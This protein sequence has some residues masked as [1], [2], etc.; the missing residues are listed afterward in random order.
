[1]SSFSQL[2]KHDIP[3]LLKNSTYEN[4]TLKITFSYDKYVPSLNSRIEN[5]LCTTLNVEMGLTNKLTSE[6]VSTKLDLLYIPVET[7]I[8]FSVGNGFKQILDLYDK[9]KGWYLLKG[10]PKNNK[11]WTIEDAIMKFYPVSGKHL[12]FACDNG[13]I[14]VVDKKNKKVGL[15]DFLKAFSGKSYKELFD[16]LGTNKYIINS[17]RDEKP[18]L[19]SVIKTG[20]LFVPTELLN[21][22]NDTVITKRVRRSL[23][24]PQYLAVNEVSRIRLESNTSFVERAE[25]TELVKKIVLP[26]GT[27]L[28]PG[29]KLLR[30]TL[31]IIDKCGIDSI[32][33]K[34][35]V[36]SSDSSKTVKSKVFELKKYGYSNDRMT[37]EELLTMVNMYANL[38]DGFGNFDEEYALTARVLINYNQKVIEAIKEK[39]I[40]IVSD[41][42][43][44][45]DLGDNKYSV[46]LW[47]LL[48]TITNF[49]K[50]DLIEFLK[51]TDAKEMQMADTSNPI[52]YASKNSKITINFKGKGSKEMVSVQGSQR[53]HLDS[54]ESP[55][56]DKVGL[57]QYKTVVSVVDKN[58][59]STKPYIRIKNGV[60]VSDEPEYLTAEDTKYA[61][62][63]EWNEKFENDEIE[64]FYDGEVVKVPKNRVTL[65]DYSPYDDMG[66]A[67]AS[68]PFQEFSNAKRLLMGSNYHRQADNIINPE[69]AIIST[70]S[71]LFLKG[72]IYTAKDLLNEYWDENSA[73]LKA[74]ITK[75]EFV[76]SPI[77]L[78]YTR[79]SKDYRT[80]TFIVSTRFNKFSFVKKLPFLQRNS[81]GS[82]FTYKLNVVKNNV[83]SGDDVVLYNGS[84]DINNY[85]IEAF[86][87]F[88]HMRVDPL[89]DLKHGLALGRNLRV[90]FKTF[91][92]SNIED[93]IVIR[94]GLVYENK[95]TSVLQKE[96]VEECCNTETQSEIFGFPDLE[97]PPE[98]YIQAN[99]LPKV[100]TFLK[101]GS[102]VICKYRIVK[103]KEI[104]GVV[105]TTKSIR[106]HYLPNNIAG[107]VKSATIEGDRAT[108]VISTISPI[109]VGDKMAGRY[110]NK[111][112]VGRIVP[113]EDMPYDSETGIPLD[114]CLNPN[115]VPS[116]M[117]LSQVLEVGLAE[118]MNI[119]GKICI[120]TPFKENTIE[121][122]KEQM[123]KS[124]VHNK[125]MIDGRTGRPFYRPIY[126]GFMYMFKLEH[127][128]NKKINS[129]SFTNAINPI[130]NQPLKGASKE[131]GQAFSEYEM[132][133]M[134][135]SNAKA[136]LNSLFSLQSDDIVAQRN[137]KEIIYSN[138]NEVDVKAM[139]NN[140]EIMQVVLRSFNVEAEVVGD[141]Y[142]FP[143]LTD[144]KTK[145]LAQSPLDTN[146]VD[147]LYY[148]FDRN[149]RRGKQKILPRDKWDWIYLG[150]ELVHPNW[151]IKSK[152]NEFIAVKYFTVK[153]INE[154][155]IDYK[156][157]LST[158]KASEFANILDEKS[159]VI[160][161]EDIPV[162]ISA[163]YAKMI[164]RF[165]YETGMSAIVRLFKTANLQLALDYYNN[166]IESQ[167]EKE[168][169]ENTKRDYFSLLKTKN[170]IEYWIENNRSLKD[171]VITTFPIIPQV[172]RP[173][174]DDVNRKHVFNQHYERIFTAIKEVKISKTNETV[175]KLYNRI[176]E[177]IGLKDF[178]K[179]GKAEIQTL[180]EIYMG[181]GKGRGKKGLLRE[182]VIK[183]RLHMSGRSVI[184][185][186]QNENLK[187]NEVGVPLLMA[188]NIWNLQLVS[189]LLKKFSAIEYTS[190]IDVNIDEQLIKDMINAIAID[191][192][193]KFCKLLNTNENNEFA[194]DLYY[195]TKK[196]IIK[197]LE[198]QVVL[199]GRQPSLQKSSC[200]AFRVRITFNK[201]IELNP[202]VCKG[203]NAD[204]DG[205]QMY[206][207]GL[208]QTQDAK[209]A[210]DKMSADKMVINPKDSS[211]LLEHSQD[212][213]LGVYFATMLHDNVKSVYEHP[214][215]NTIHCV[216]SL[217]ALDLALEL[218]EIHPHD[219]VTVEVNGRRY[220]ST[221][222]RIQF[223][224]LL[225]NGFT[226]E[227]F[228]NN[229][230]L[231]VI[232]AEN[233]ALCGDFNGSQVPAINPNRYC[234]L[235]FDGL[236]SKKGGNK[237]GMVYYSLSKYTKELYYKEP[238]DV[239]I[240]VYQ[241]IMK[242]G[243]RYCDLSGITISLDDLDIN[244]D[245]DSY[246][247]KAKAQADIVNQAFY[248]G[249]VS[250]KGRKS[251]VTDI[252]NTL[253]EYLKNEVIFKQ[254]P[255]NN[256]LAIML[257]SGSRGDK[258]Q[259]MQTLGIV[260]ISMKTGEESL[261]TPILNSYSTGLTSFELFLA[262]YGARVGVNSTQNETADAGYA[263]RQ[264]VY[265]CGGT[266][267]VEDDCGNP[268]DIV[269][270]NYDS[271]AYIVDPKGNITH[272]PEESKKIGGVS[273]S[274]EKAL[275]VL[276]GK[277]IS[278]SDELCSKLLF[279]FLPADR[280]I[281]SECIRQIIKHKVR[282]VTCVSEK[283]INGETR[284]V[285]EVYQLRY[286]LNPTIKDLLLYRYLTEDTLDLKAGTYLTESD[287]DKIEKA[288]L[289]KLHVR[290]LF[291]C[292]SEG[293]V[294]AKCFGL[295][296]DTLQL[297]EINEYV[298]IESAQSI[299][300]PAAQL[301]MSLFHAGGISGGASSGV[302]FFKQCIKG[303]EP[304]KHDKAC[305]SKVDGYISYKTLGK[306]AYINNGDLVEVVD[307]DKL[308]V[309]Q[310]EY[311]Q[312]GTQLTSGVVP[313][314][315]IGDLRPSLE[316]IRKRQ[317]ELLEVYDNV[318]RSNNLT[319]HA[320]HFE[321]LVR[322]QT[323]L[324][325]IYESDDPAIPVGSLKELATVLTSIEKGHHIVYDQK[326]SK[327]NEVISHFS[328]PVSSLVFERFDENLASFNTRLP[329]YYDNSIMGR[330]A[331]GEDVRD[332]FD[333]DGNLLPPKRAKLVHGIFKAND[334]EDFEPAEELDSTI[335]VIDFN[336]STVAMNLEID[337]EGEN[338]DFAEQP[339]DDI[340]EHID[341]DE[342]I[343][344]EA[345]KVT[346]DDKLS[347]LEVF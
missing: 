141:K 212:M 259:L 25:G 291:T 82:T 239:C 134:I 125:I 10:K 41:L 115:G 60:A 175:L 101:A 88:G 3:E 149:R 26:D 27:I 126:V 295:K 346:E 186:T 50:N 284:E 170:D 198:N 20:E 89:K 263:T 282:S 183:K 85:D 94:R 19:D 47:D 106:N 44:N 203:Y 177:F 225:P 309:Q 178:G 31:E 154:D 54:I 304:K 257:D 322:V 244:I 342:I 290:L 214:A 311:V 266:R 173:L 296:F 314:N 34:K 72:L 128:V 188:V 199:F 246:I 269:Y 142:E 241:E 146:N 234:N 77:T 286:K 48:T 227:P 123:K 190:K 66:I 278:T 133:C 195:N 245:L 74:T 315:E 165:N 330:I 312:V 86:A 171:Y 42:T 78:Q 59:L 193:A 237:D 228:T 104:D 118:A 232:S 261:E 220:L 285:E 205:D 13:K 191:N 201:A 337:T 7:E 230:K 283:I 131:G 137:L 136:P 210:F 320:R 114:V 335:E 196:F 327:Q 16:L 268:D 302:Q 110:G 79:I 5:T 24:N 331:I 194:K 144:A 206:L 334:V 28:Q 73:T 158:L 316:I 253:T 344:E 305:M 207:I 187:I 298:G 213:V 328:G 256:N 262:S 252:Y 151:L 250:E 185:P 219:L 157:K 324:V 15:G 223:N 39:L 255:R 67:R 102:L 21:S 172:F 70:G 116:R 97:N 80:Y 9:A 167:K 153:G 248:D 43:N 166:E 49:Q 155:N 294:C 103:G 95:L 258:G 96:I 105:T 143:V 37:V 272:A 180:Q 90:G 122:I 249:L 53:G 160:F 45:F 100:G 276:F 174:T 279:N 231:P 306:K 120:A 117:N 168:E 264:C 271:L 147:S 58:G 1:M 308:L 303:T 215:Y 135:S 277:T 182:S 2:M 111:G 313:I 107:E 270:L 112:V 338:Y 87:D 22:R 132:W 197:V 140:D 108:V 323:T 189:H 18:L 152:L 179:K 293:G 242:F 91:S 332:E 35:D 30:S 347:N 40:I 333:E 318:Y 162:I 340:I 216:S 287:I 109:E 307:V 62:I 46:N 113:D 341:L 184:I 267:I 289:E 17:L 301:S 236:I 38:L 68:I 130:T 254:I 8:G 229:L 119:Q 98:E 251:M 61:Y 297:P 23:L 200:K 321:I 222:G 150:C 238:L 93:A 71:E 281:T 336:D 64:A 243:F 12:T 76:N 83:Y 299:G 148:N 233:N 156:L 217:E 29:T 169:T 329:E 176:A 218:R 14:I 339:F 121:Y 99:G 235:L 275:Q 326:V 310:G 343:E 163:E 159:Y 260:G 36:E 273:L 208:A 33:I 288:N 221:A 164:D 274:E 6:Y 65:Q 51:S 138:P 280:T 84:I 319:I 4:D 209:E 55:E 265:M 226:S 345:T 192:I 240:D 211:N 317:M 124:D 63:A 247:D 32:T 127:M 204:F 181:K 92:T 325:K 52:A 161:S 139:N 56:S 69:R 224:R 145:A 129:I 75:E 81:K 11:T 292:R 300:E 202:L 57:T